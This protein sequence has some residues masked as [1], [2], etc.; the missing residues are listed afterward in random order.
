MRSMKTCVLST[1]FLICALAMLAGQRPAGKPGV[2][3]APFG[4]MPDGRSVEVFTLTNANGVEVR[5]ITYGGIITSLRVPDRQGTSGDVVLGFDGLEPYLKGHPFFGAIVGRYGNRI[6]GGQFTLDGRTY[7]LATNN[8]PNHLHGGNVGFDKAVWAAE[9]LASGVG[10]A[11][12]HTSP[13]GDEGYPGTLKVRVTYTLTDRNELAVEYRATTDKPTPVNLTQHSYFNLAGSGDILGHELRIDA[14]RFTPVDDTL[15]PTGELAPVD[16]TPF[17]FRTPTLV[18]A[19]IDGSDTQ[20]KYGRGYDHNFVLNGSAGVLRPVVRLVEPKSGRTLDV[21]TTEP[22]LQFYTGNFLD[23]TLKGKGGQ[24]YNRRAG[25]CLETQHY[26]DSPNKPSFPSA[27][28]RPG[29]DYHSR[30]VFR[31]GVAG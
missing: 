6:A 17:D 10:V 2:T 28:V 21:A 16:G 20:L 18:G 26:P 14:N 3:R 4:K 25:L 9:P 24:V 22:G 30:T 29:K 31:F 19:R 27:I 12:S 7:K 15:I 13:D 11:F 1:A 8:G 5:A 23:G